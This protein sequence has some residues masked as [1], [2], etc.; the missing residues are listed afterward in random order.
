[1]L[2]KLA[3]AGAIDPDEAVVT[4]ISGIGLKTLEAVESLLAAALRIKPTLASFEERV[5]QLT[6]A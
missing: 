5:L 6:R 4:I 2:R 3:Q 1:V